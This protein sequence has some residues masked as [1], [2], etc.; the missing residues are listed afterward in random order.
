MQLNMRVIRRKSMRMRMTRKNE[1]VIVGIQS[2]LIKNCAPGP[3]SS[4]EIRPPR[5]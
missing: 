4:S 3:V 2:K 1:A 5:A